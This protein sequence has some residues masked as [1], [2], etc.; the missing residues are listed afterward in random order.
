MKCPKCGIPISKA[1][2]FCSNCGMR[3][4]TN[5]GD[6]ARD[7]S[8]S[9]DAL[10]LLKMLNEFRA[11][12]DQSEKINVRFMKTYKQK[13][14]DEIGPSIRQFKEKYGN[15][16]AGKSKKFELVLET[17]AC[18]SRPIAFMQTKLRPSVGMGV[19][20]ERWM[21]T[22]VVED[23]LKECCQEADRH[24]NE[25]KQKLAYF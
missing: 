18:L 22:K 15:N 9:S 12:I 6:Q 10:D 14:E 23:F 5:N 21:M 1:D 19:W 3:I 4:R 13:I 16:E 7:D 8:F 20:Q 2:I 11:W 17:Y 24:I 25:L